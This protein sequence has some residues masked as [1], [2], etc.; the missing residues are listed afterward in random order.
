MLFYINNRNLILNLTRLYL[1][2]HTHK[3]T[4]NTTRRIVFIY[5]FAL[6]RYSISYLN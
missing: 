1:R 5:N 6:I 2:L 4:M 3:F